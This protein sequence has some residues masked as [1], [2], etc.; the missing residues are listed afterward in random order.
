MELFLPDILQQI[1]VIQ[2]R[3]I[4]TANPELLFEYFNFIAHTMARY[5]T[6]WDVDYVQRWMLSILVSLGIP[7]AGMSFQGAIEFLV[8]QL[9][10]NL[11]LDNSPQPGL[12]AS[13]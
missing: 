2:F 9:F 12:S 5:S 10:R 8:H 3:E 13:F 7:E 1:P 4:T 11:T 6:A